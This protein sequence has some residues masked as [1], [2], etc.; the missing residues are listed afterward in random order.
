MTKLWNGEILDPFLTH[1][2][3]QRIPIESHGERNGVRK[4]VSNAILT[5]VKESYS[6]PKDLITTKNEK[7]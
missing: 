1:P 3:N 4:N 5:C 2:S 7:N 6:L